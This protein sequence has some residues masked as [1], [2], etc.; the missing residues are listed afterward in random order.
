MNIGHHSI[1]FLENKVENQ[2]DCNKG[3]VVKGVDTLQGIQWHELLQGEA[4][5]QKEGLVW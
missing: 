4:A 5:I 3:T 1:K 2:L